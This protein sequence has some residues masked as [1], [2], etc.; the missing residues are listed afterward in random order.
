MFR[1]RACITL[2]LVA[3]VLVAGTLNAQAGDNAVQKKSY[4]SAGKSGSVVR[5]ADGSGSKK[6]HSLTITADD[7]G[8]SSNRCT[9]TWIDLSTSNPHKHFNP[10]V[11]VNCTGK[12]ITVSNQYV[13]DW[14]GV[15]SVGLIVCEVPNTS[16]RVVRNRSNCRGNI[17]S[18]YQWSGKSY[19]SFDSPGIS[20][21]NGAKQWIFR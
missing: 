14:I 18:M 20:H 17:G 13:T 9:E 7:S 19:G 11:L 16:G 3:S 10:G 15:R 6:T 2:A 12:K 5:Y 4:S 21:P 1:R 8:G